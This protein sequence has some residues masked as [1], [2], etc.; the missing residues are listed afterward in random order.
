MPLRRFAAYFVGISVCSTIAFAAC[1]ADHPVSQSAGIPMDSPA[2]DKPDAP[3]LTSVSHG[4]PAH[5]T[6][7]VATAE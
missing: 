1:A 7:L 3:T 2:V 6:L 4:R 5:K